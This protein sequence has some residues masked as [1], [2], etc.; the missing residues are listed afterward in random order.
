MKAFNKF[1]AALTA[2]VLSLSCV[3]T[4]FAAES[5]V[6]YIGNAKKFIFAPGSKYSLTDLFDN[7][8]NVMPGDKLTQKILVK[9]GVENNVKI[10]VYMR[11]LGAQKSTDDFLRQ[12]TLTVTQDGTSQLFKASS[13]KKAQL[14]DWVCLG[15]IYSG[16]EI[17]LDV[18]LDVPL[19]LDT[20]YQEEI[21]YI[22]WQFSIEEFPVD[23][24]DPKPPKTS[25]EFSFYFWLCIMLICAVVMTIAATMMRKHKQKRLYSD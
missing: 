4:V 7:F 10:K 22:D 14:T 5:S 9:N 15:T 12:M 2:I 20:K 24:D 16:G 8:K 1:A 23:D 13:D 19:T 21:G 11:S 17:T 3:M 25:D 18:T 6:S